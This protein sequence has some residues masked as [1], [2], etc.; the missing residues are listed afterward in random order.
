MNK[1]LTP[2]SALLNWFELVF[3]LFGQSNMHL[4]L[5]LISAQTSQREIKCTKGKK[6]LEITVLIYILC[7]QATIRVVNSPDNIVGNGPFVPSNSYGSSLT[8][9]TSRNNPFK[10]NKVS[11]LSLV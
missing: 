3:G 10:I 2:V 6:L 9:E 8:P 7:F 1:V 4:T 5:D 11:N